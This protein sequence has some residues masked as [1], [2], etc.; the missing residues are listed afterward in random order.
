MWQLTL[1]RFK[2]INIGKKTRE[3]NIHEQTYL[4]FVERIAMYVFNRMQGLCWTGDGQGNSCSQR[5]MGAC[6]RFF[7]ILLDLRMN[8]FRNH[9][10]ALGARCMPPSKPIKFSDS[11]DIPSFSCGVLSLL[12]LL[13]P[14]SLWKQCFP[15]YWP[16]G[17]SVWLTTFPFSMQNA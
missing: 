5:G 1:G 8:S 2:Y 3:L 4:C 10:V 15:F 17:F 9:A 14:I 16:M 11:S 12:R 7:W 13:D 6:R